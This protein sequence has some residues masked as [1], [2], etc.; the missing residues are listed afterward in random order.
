MSESVFKKIYVKKIGIRRFTGLI[1][2]TGKLSCKVRLDRLGAYALDFNRETFEQY[3]MLKDWVGWMW[4][5]C[6]LF[7]EILEL[8]VTVFEI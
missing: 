7:Q 6:C 3:D 5:R 4:Q 8:R 2:E 1:S